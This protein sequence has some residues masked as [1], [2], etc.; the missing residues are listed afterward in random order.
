MSSIHDAI[1]TTVTGMSIGFGL[2]AFAMWPLL[3]M[4]RAA[5]YAAT[6]DDTTGLPNRRAFYAHLGLAVRRGRIA[7]VLLDLNAFKTI[8]DRH[9]HQAGDV[10]L[11]RV[12]ARLAALPAPT[13]YAAR[14]SGDEFAML[15][16]DRTGDAMTAA[17]A[18]WATIAAAPVHLRDGERVDVTASVGVAVSRPG[19]NPRTLLH[20]ADLAMYTAKRT[21]SRVHMYPTNA[22][23]PYGQVTDRPRLRARDQLQ[24]A[25]AI[26]DAGQPALVRHA[27]NVGGRAPDRAA[28]TV[29]DH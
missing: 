17:H 22:D 29:R 7:V 19:T 8:N 10:V 11:A 13:M 3:R 27:S 26:P 25:I 6:H 5:R 28:T 15:I 9:G 16:D 14:L 1:A 24:R 18:A 21:N 23:D 2:A 20:H 12:A 4:L